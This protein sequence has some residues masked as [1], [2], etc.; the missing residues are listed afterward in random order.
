[1]KAQATFLRHGERQA[2]VIFRWPVSTVSSF[3]SGAIVGT[4]RSR[5]MAAFRSCTCSA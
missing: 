3:S 5:S 2:D 1:M 4:Q